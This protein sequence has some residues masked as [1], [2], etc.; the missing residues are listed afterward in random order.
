M[1]QHNVYSIQTCKRRK[2]RSIS[3]I[4]QRLFQKETAHYIRRLCIDSCN[5][6]IFQWLQMTQKIWMSFG[7][8]TTNRLNGLKWKSIELLY[9]NSV[10]FQSFNNCNKTNRVSNLIILC[11]LIYLLSTSATIYSNRT[12]N[13]VPK[14]FLHDLEKVIRCYLL[15]LIPRIVFI[16]NHILRMQL[17]KCACR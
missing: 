12:S 14:L 1:N 3:Y 17:A 9:N 11:C 13:S 16:V 6:E 7:N 8:V 2:I 4:K 10:A 5:F 15:R